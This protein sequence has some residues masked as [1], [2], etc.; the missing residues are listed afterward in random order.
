M[1]F[2]IAKI[3]ELPGASLS[4]SE[5]CNIYV[6]PQRVGRHIVFPWA[7]VRLSVCLLRIVSAL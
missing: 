3:K 2:Q 4:S 7:S 1:G 6:S 5:K